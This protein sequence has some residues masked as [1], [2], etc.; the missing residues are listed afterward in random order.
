MN[1]EPNYPLAATQGADIIGGGKMYNPTV[2]VNIDQRIK[3]AQDQVERLQGVRIKLEKSGLLDIP[4]GDLR[5]A[6]Q[7]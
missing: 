1:I 3:Q 4:I 2:R 7:F 5:D 6:M